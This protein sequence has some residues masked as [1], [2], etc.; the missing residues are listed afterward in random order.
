MAK[1]AS[2]KENIPTILQLIEE[3]KSLRKA[4]KEKDVKAPTFMLWVREDPA[5]AEQYAQAREAGLEKMA[6]D[7]ID[8]SDRENADPQRDRLRVDARKWLLSKMM[9]KKYGDKLTLGGDPEEPLKVHI[10]REVIGSKQ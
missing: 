7:I 3:G 5:L 4:C 10:T 9:P 8:I 6:E 1:K 2:G